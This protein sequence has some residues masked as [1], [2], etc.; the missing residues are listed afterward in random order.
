MELAKTAS[1]P[2]SPLRT[3]WAPP[4]MMFLPSKAP[5]RSSLRTNLITDLPRFIFRMLSCTHG[6]TLAPTPSRCDCCLRLIP[7]GRNISQSA[8]PRT[9][10]LPSK[11]PRRNS[12]RTNLSTGFPRFISRMVSSAHGTTPAPTLSR[13]GL[14]HNEANMARNGNSAIIRNARV[15]IFQ[16]DS[17]KRHETSVGETP[18]PRKRR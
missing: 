17:G 12:L 16:R 15:L 4:R 14:H 13:C 2:F 9:T 1:E 10:S 7:L 18:L 8:P 11:G 5:R 3:Q 6:T